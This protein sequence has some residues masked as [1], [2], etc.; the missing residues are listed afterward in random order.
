MLLLAYFFGV[1]FFNLFG[2]FWDRQDL[3]QSIYYISI[4]ILSSVTTLTFKS[5]V[6]TR[7]ESIIKLQSAINALSIMKITGHTTERNF[8]KYIKVTPKEH[9]EN[10]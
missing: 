9:A 2:F 1:L 3:P 8:L 7:R 5:L 4:I 10:Y 6:H